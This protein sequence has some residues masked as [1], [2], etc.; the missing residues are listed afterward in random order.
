M[1]EWRR[2]WVGVGVQELDCV[3]F[4][5]WEEAT[6]EVLRLGGPVEQVAAGFGYSLVAGPLAQVDQVGAG[7]RGPA[8]RVDAGLGRGDWVKKRWG[9]G[10]DRVLNYAASSP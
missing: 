9:C 8:K 6:E 4:D 7:L 1:V 10:V 2:G 3:H 5:V